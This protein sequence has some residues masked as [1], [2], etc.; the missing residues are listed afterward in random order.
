MVSEKVIKLKSNSEKY[1]KHKYEMPDEY[2]ETPRV[3]VTKESKDDKMKRLNFK[4]E[5]KTENQMMDLIPEHY[6]YDGHVFLMTDGNQTY[7]VRWDESLKEGT[8][9]SY[10]NKS[11]I[12]EDTDKMK[13]LFN[14]K[15]SDS[16]GKTNDYNKE[17]DTFKNLFESTKGKTLL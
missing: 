13:K 10:K 14:Y 16:M 11:M 5:F 8:V 15:Y 1:M 9:L 2:Q 4:N 6:K 3:R 12:N 7:K 17:T